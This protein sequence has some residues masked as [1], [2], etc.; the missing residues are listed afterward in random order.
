MNFCEAK[1]MHPFYST[2]GVLSPLELDFRL[3]FI[4]FAL[5]T[6]YLHWNFN[7]YISTLWNKARNKDNKK[8]RN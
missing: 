5:F 6:Y 3:D 2:V 1:T 7:L 4:V 8:L